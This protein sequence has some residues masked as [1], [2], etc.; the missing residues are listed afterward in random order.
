MDKAKS[1][2]R[3]VVKQKEVNRPS[4]NPKFPDTFV[5]VQQDIGDDYGNYVKVVAQPHEI[6]D[7]DVDDEVTIMAEVVGRRYQKEGIEDCFTKLELTS[8][9]SKVKKVEEFKPGEDQDIPF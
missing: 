7:I 5:V 9:E 3:G 4:R 8:I 1:I 6:A 2:V